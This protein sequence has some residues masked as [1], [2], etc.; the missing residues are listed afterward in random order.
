MVAQN[1]RPPSILQPGQ[2]V[3]G[4]QHK[5][6]PSL[7]PVSLQVATPAGAQVFQ[8]G[9]MTRAELLAAIL[10]HGAGKPIS[11]ISDDDL[12]RAWELASKLVEMAEAPKPQ[13][14]ACSN[15]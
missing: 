3:I 8:F 11:Q 7:V 10:L 9:G 1:N 6:T 5:P 13:G 4:F 2:G 12:G 14:E 15:G